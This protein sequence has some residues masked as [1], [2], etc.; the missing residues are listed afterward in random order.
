MSILFVDESGANIDELTELASQGIYCKNFLKC[1]FEDYSNDE[2]VHNDPAKFEIELLEMKYAR[3]AFL[4]A[5]QDPN[6][7]IYDKE[8]LW[9][10]LPPL[11]RKLE[12]AKPALLSTEGLTCLSLSFV[13]GSRNLTPDQMP[14]LVG[15]LH[16]FCCSE[17]I[18]I[19]STLS[20]GNFGGIE[21]RI[22]LKDDHKCE[23]NIFWSPSNQFDM[24][25]VASM[26]SN[27]SGVIETSPILSELLKLKKI[28]KIDENGKVDAVFD[29]NKAV[30]TAIDDCMKTQS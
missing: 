25:H 9:F 7:N 24:S 13:A 26:A 8:A 5:D 21:T 22:D 14:W 12:N 15:L 20:K 10:Y 1:L 17:T 11:C 27:I 6:R 30:K 18:S 19:S 2:E 28:D 29:M 3:I 16:E 4:I 23:I